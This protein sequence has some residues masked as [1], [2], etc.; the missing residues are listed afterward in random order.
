[1]PSIDMNELFKRNPREF[2]TRLLVTR[3]GEKRVAKERLGDARDSTQRRPIEREIER[4]D[5][6]IRYH[7]TELQ[8]LQAK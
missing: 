5:D 3:Q 7:K 8:K 1:M 6:D 2:H 4:L